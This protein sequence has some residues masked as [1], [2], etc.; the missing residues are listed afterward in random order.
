MHIVCACRS[1][2][3]AQLNRF[4]SCRNYRCG[5]CGDSSSILWPQ[6]DLRV[7]NFK[8]F[9]GGA[10]PQTSLASLHLSAH[11]GHTTLKQLAPTL[12]I[13]QLIFAQLCQIWGGAWATLLDELWQCICS[14]LNFR[15]Y[16]C[17]FTQVFMFGTINPKPWQMWVVPLAKTCN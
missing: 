17:I 5:G 12:Y 2:L 7:A 11:N 8:N 9:P 4:S 3:A 1:F 15:Q 16:S 6:S 13:N 10:C 14:I